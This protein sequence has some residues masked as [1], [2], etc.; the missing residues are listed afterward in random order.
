MPLNAST[1]FPPGGIR[2]AG[3]EEGKGCIDGV[4]IRTGRNF[5]GV[6]IHTVPALFLEAFL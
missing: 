6:W 5:I 3:P 4:M 1:S 2:P